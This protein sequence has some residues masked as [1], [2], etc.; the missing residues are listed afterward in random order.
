[1]HFFLQVS[2]PISDVN[3]TIE[4][5]TVKYLIGDTVCNSR[6]IELNDQACVGDVCS[7][8]SVISNSSCTVEAGSCITVAVSAT[9]GLGTGESRL[10]LGKLMC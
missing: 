8:T 5:F 9:S 7:V 10:E 6:M 3:A 1:M 2:I 4:F